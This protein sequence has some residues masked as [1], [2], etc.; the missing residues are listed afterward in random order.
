MA[1]TAGGTSRPGPD[2]ASGLRASDTE[3]DA[4]VSELGQHFQDGRLD[5]GEFSQRVGAALA[6]RTRGDLDQLMTDLPRPSAAGAGPARPGAVIRRRPAMLAL[7]PL[8]IAVVIVAGGFGGWHHHGWG[9]G[10][11][12]PFGF[13]WLIV[14][15]L[16]V[17]FWLLGSRRRQW[18]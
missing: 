6:A 11:F 5:T 10:P 14:P 15:V 8:V 18:R 1:S 12:A 7:V 3:R 2:P 4:I 17:R 16:A 9:G 13:L